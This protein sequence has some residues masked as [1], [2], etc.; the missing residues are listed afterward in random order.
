MIKKEFTKE[1]NYNYLLGL[2]NSTY[3]RFIYIQSVKELGRVFPQIKLEK[4][5]SLPIKKISLEQQFPFIELVDRI[6]SITK[7]GDYLENPDKKAKV[8]R[9]EN[10][11]DQLVYKL[12]DLTKE[13][14]ELVESS[15]SN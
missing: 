9:L 15:I 6:L 10:E 2:L 7:D 11:I 8:K 1:L 14:I 4:L 13:E 12:Y 3:I 5:A